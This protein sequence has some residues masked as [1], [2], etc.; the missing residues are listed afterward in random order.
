MIQARAGTRNIVPLMVRVP[1]DLRERI[2]AAAEA[3]GRSQNSEIVA[4][5]EEKYPEPPLDDWLLAAMSQIGI[6]LREITPA[7]VERVKERINEDLSRMA[8]RIGR[9]S[10]QAAAHDVDGVEEP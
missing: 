9:K 4:T 8:E 5:L 6:D 7:D 2:K 3:N 1:E 10:E